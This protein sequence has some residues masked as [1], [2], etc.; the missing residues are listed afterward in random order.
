MGY[1]R[2]HAIIVTSFMPERTQA[3]HDKAV[4]LGMAVTSI[5]SGSINGYTSF[6]IAPD[7]SKE[8]WDGSTKGDQQRAAMVEYLDAQRHDDD[9]SSI[10]WVEVQFGDDDMDTCIIRDNDEHRRA[11]YGMPN[12]LP[13]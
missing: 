3:A 11:G 10:D 2:H 12:R 7:G 9:S 4:E 1:M 13:A 6:L 5:V 8:G